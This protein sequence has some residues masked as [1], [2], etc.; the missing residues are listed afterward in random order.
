MADT[1]EIIYLNENLGLTELSDGEHTILTTDAATSYV[2]K[3]MYVKNT[4]FITSDTRL[5]LNGF[6]AGSLTSNATGS[7]IVPPNSTLKVKSSTYP[8]TYLEESL[9]VTTNA[10]VP[11]YERSIR[12]L[13][14]TSP[15]VT[16]ESV[17]AQTAFSSY[18]G[19][20]ININYNV[21]DDSN[22]YFYAETTDNNSAQS[23]Q[24]IGPSGGAAQV[25][26]S[27]Y[28]ALG[29]GFKEN[30]DFIGYRSSST[31]FYVKDFDAYPTSKPDSSPTLLNVN[32]SPYPESSYP[33]HFFAFDHI[34]FVP[35]SSYPTQVY[36]VNVNNGSFKS[37][38]GLRGW[39]SNSGN[40]FLTVSHDISTDKM[41]IWRMDGTTNAVV[42]EIS[43]TKTEFLADNSS[44][45]KGVVTPGTRITHSKT[46]NAGWPTLGIVS[47]LSDGGVM[48]RSSTNTFES[49]DV[50]GETTADPIST[51]SVTVAGITSPVYY[52]RKSSRVLSTAEAVAAGVTL[53]TFG[54]QLLGVKSESV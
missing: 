16:Y 1:L 31:T 54:I 32:K 35:S 22:P 18:V 9:I 11:K 15:E 48:F 12:K 6:D 13:G 19:D 2:I 4:D 39:A 14:G 50:T 44:G 3:D 51:A 23:L 46:R 49:I 30:G 42:T 41:Y 29:T 21:A 8:L 25:E 24:R 5:E 36:A 27:N 40:N 43:Q 28:I 33:R 17:T 7:L 45:A 53:L 34:W 52:Y 37:Y 10:N 38:T 47:P 20:M 26:Y